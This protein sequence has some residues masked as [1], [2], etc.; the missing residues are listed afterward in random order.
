[1]IML[2]NIYIYVYLFYI[3]IYYT[4]KNV[5]YPMYSPF[6]YNKGYISLNHLSLG[7]REMKMNGGK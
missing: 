2:H 5:N 3:I 6:N 4:A 7:H 1:M